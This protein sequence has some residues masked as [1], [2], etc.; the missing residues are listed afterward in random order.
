M[1]SNFSNN[2]SLHYSR[3]IVNF[4]LKHRKHK[5]FQAIRKLVFLIS[6][7][8]GDMTT[9]PRKQQFVVFVNSSQQRARIC[10]RQQLGNFMKRI[11]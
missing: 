1:N 5:G 7:D 2:L 4:L 8:N 9:T 10:N 11:N 6:R 3:K